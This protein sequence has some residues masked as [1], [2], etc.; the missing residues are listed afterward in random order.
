MDSPEHG[1]GDETSNPVNPYAAPRAAISK[2]PANPKLERLIA[3][4]ILE[5]RE[6]GGYSL[7]L[8]LRWQKLRY[9]LMIVYFSVAIG[10]SAYRELWGLLWLVL[11]LLIGIMLRDLG[12]FRAS[13]RSWPFNE[14][15]IDWE[16]VR[17]IA[18]GEV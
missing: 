1:D 6:Q 11:G 10:L 7:G 17:Q 13:A 2:S 12:W 3:R 4:R 9:L 15:V 5:A 16:K 18:D 14:R 8:F